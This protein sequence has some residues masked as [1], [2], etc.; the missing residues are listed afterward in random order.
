MAFK[1][2]LRGV[3]GV[4]D[5]FGGFGMT[6]TAEDNKQKALEK[7]LSDLKAYRPEAIQMRQN[8]LDNAMKLFQPLNTALG[9]QYGAD[10]M[11]P[12]QEA[13]KSPMDQAMKNMAATQA[14]ETAQAAAKNA[15]DFGGLSRVP[16][17]DAR[18]ECR[19][20]GSRPAIDAAIDARSVTDPDRSRA[21]RLGCLGQYPMGREAA[22]REP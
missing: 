7:A 22:P 21:H 16:N 5:V 20:P 4:G 12:L 2:F 9:Q 8:S 11:L 19:L 18:V 3:P 10:A 15:E 13:T 17:P 6:T 1:D 14:A